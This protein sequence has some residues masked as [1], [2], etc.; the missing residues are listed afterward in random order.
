MKKLISVIL[1]INFFFITS[2]LS[3]EIINPKILKVA[4]LPDENAARIIKKHQKFKDY[5]ENKLNKKIELVV[6]SDYSSMIEAI[7]FKRIHIGYFGPLSYTIAK[8]KTN[9]TPF[10]VREKNGKIT[11]NSIIIGNKELNILNLSDV[12]GKSFGFGD[13][14]STSSHLIP[15]KML[16]DS[17][18]REK[19]DYKSIFLGAHDAVAISVQN[20]NISAGGLSLPIYKLLLEKKI[21]DKDKINEIKISSNYPQYPWVFIDELDSKLKTKIINAFIM[22]KDEDILAQMGG[23]AFKKVRDEDYDIIRQ[24]AKKLSIFNFQ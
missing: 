16:I 1:F 21:I 12:K 10:A 24:L 13:V 9:I 17:G 19:K 6:T 23:T 5:L 3:S 11:Y 2:L 7:R 14:A 15:K 22:L 8:S 20:G 4:L 18:L